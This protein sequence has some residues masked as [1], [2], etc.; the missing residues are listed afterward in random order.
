MK[1]LLL[2]FVCVIVLLSL[3]HVCLRFLG[4]RPAIPESFAELSGKRKLPEQPE[5]LEGLSPGIAENFSSATAG[6]SESGVEVQSLSFGKACAKIFFFLVALA[7]MGGL[8]I[9][10]RRRGGLSPVGRGGSHIAVL[11]TLRLGTKHYLAV[12]ECGRR[13]FFIGVTQQNVALICELTGE[14]YL[15]KSEKLG[16]EN[17]Q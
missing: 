3:P 11:E 6:N 12:V 5:D 14:K 7:A 2:L 1:R 13:Q 4:H 10:L 15:E 9:F 17:G 8:L 16:A